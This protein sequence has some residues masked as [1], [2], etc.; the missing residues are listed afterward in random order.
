MLRTSAS[1]RAPKK[2]PPAKKPSA[3]KKALP[4]RKASK[5]PVKSAARAVQSAGDR[6][7]QTQLAYAEIKRRILDN[8]M[9][10]DS[11]YLEQELAEELGMSRTPVREAL[12]RLADE[13]LV[14]IIPRHG[15]RVLPLSIEDMREVYELLTEL[16][17]VA[18]RRVAERTPSPKQ[19]AELEAAVAAMDQALLRDDLYAWAKH[20]DRFHRKLVELSGNSRLKSVVGTFSDQVHRARMQTLMKRPRPVDSNRDHAAVVAAIRNGDGNQAYTI[21]RRHREQAGAMLL[22]LLERLGVDAL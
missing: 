22:K 1:R 20:D 10:A 15:A 5:K 8:A 2:A 7:S 18:A 9:P 3:A 4:A 17:A 16:E 19:L 14:E 6:V 11:Q 21:H 13:R 12:I